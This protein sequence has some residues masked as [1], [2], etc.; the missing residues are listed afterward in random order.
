MLLLSKVCMYD[1]LGFMWKN[2]LIFTTTCNENMI[3][4]QSMYKY[5]QKDCFIF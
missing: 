1:Y 3:K 5:I 2:I 4:F